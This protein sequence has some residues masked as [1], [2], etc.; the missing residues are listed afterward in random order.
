MTIE[1]FYKDVYLTCEGVSIDTRTIRP[2]EVFIALPGK[3]VNANTFAQTAI[4]K[5][6]NAALV[7]EKDY[8]NFHQNIFYVTDTLVF[9]QQLARYHRK[10]LTIPIIALT[11]SNGKTT[12]KE[13]MA[14]VLSKKFRTLSTPGNYNNHIGVPITVL[15]IMPHHEIAVVEMGANHQKEIEFLSGISNP[16]IGYITNFGKAHLEGF[17]GVEGVIKGKSE[18]Y[19]HQRQTQKMV[20]VNADD[21]KQMELSGGIERITFGESSFADYTFSYIID[22]EFAQVEF[23]G[24]IFQTQL[25]GHYNCP[26]IAAAITLGLHFGVDISAIKHAIESYEPENNRSQMLTTAGGKQIV[27]D[28]YN[29]NPNSMEASVVAFAQRT[30]QKCVILGDMYELG[31]DSD[32]EHRKIVELVESLPIEHAFFIGENFAQVA[33]GKHNFYLS[34]EEFLKTISSLKLP[35]QILLKGSRA[36]ELERLVPFLT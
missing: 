28:C 13:L 11:G 12:S 5:G 10:Q 17:G 8:E 18:L 25:V 36:M 7:F 33:N 14:A 20:L 16:D 6:A 31:E 23:D 29:A 34:T 24:L 22:K 9:L 26:N 30:G 1:Q 3:N 35:Q 32:F 27:V 4:E 21:A 19:V 15:S 2:G